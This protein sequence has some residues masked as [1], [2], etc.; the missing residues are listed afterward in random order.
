MTQRVRRRWLSAFLNPNALRVTSLITRLM[1]SLLA[2]LWPVS[3]NAAISVPQRS[4]VA[5]RVRTSGVSESAH[6]VRNFQR[7]WPT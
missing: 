6:Q 2:L 3:M 4:T 1:P 7:A 5:A